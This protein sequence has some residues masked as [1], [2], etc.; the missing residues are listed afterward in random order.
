MATMEDS[1]WDDG[2]ACAQLEA[3]IERVLAAW[4]EGRSL[5]PL[6]YMLRDATRRVA[7]KEVQDEVRNGDPIT[8][9]KILVSCGL[10]RAL[11]REI[12]G[13]QVK[14]ARK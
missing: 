1:T 11:A 14:Q 10:T 9:M 2:R 13:W 12:V 7:T 6:A 4:P 5:L 3:E 8:A